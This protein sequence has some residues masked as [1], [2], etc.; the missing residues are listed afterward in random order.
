MEIWKDIQGFEGRFQAS[1]HGRIK[2]LYVEIVQKNGRVYKRKETILKPS[3]MTSSKYLFVSL[4]FNRETRK[5]YSVHRLVCETFNGSSNGKECNHKDGDKYNNHYLNLEWVTR[6]ENLEHQRINKLYAYG[7]NNYH[8]ILKEADVVEIKKY[9]FPV[10]Y[11]MLSLIA[12]KY[13]VSAAS[14]R[15]VLTGKTWKHVR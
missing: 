2:S 9:G 10:K 6:K 12:R 3:K 15:D 5:G 4:G 1:T 8:A 7:S 14:I 11:G 13:K